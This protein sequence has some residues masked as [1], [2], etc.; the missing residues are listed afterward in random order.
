LPARLSRTKKNDVAPTRLRED[1]AMKRT[2]RLGLIG[3]L[4]AAVTIGAVACGGSAEVPA[5]EDAAADGSVETV[6][7]KIG[8][9]T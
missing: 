5:L 3:I 4:L 9:M 1:V 6:S 2:Q 8:G 7:L